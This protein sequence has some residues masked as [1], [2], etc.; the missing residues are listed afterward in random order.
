MKMAHLEALEERKVKKS[1]EDH[2]IE[3]V[4]KLEAAEDGGFQDK[5][6]LMQ[7]Y[8]HFN[9]AVKLQKQEIKYLNTMAYFLILVGNHKNALT[10]LATS[11]KIDPKND[12]ALK[13]QQSVQ[14]IMHMTP[15]QKQKYAVEAFSNRPYPKSDDDFDALY[16]A[17]EDFIEEQ[18][19][20]FMQ[21]TVSPEVTLDAAKVDEQQKM[22]AQL[23]EIQETVVEKLKIL[24]Q[25]QDVSALWDKTRNLEALNTRYYNSLRLNSIF[26]MVLDGINEARTMTMEIFQEIKQK[27]D[28]EVQALDLDPQINQ[29]YDYCDE[30]ADQLDRLSQ[31]TNIYLLEREYESLIQFVQH[32]QDTLDDY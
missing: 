12:S 29:I 19:R 26:M 20:Y 3:G 22:F 9:A 6:A 23:E 27:S 10:Y 8:Q 25:D 4:K 32:L 1:A 24:E 17:L 16:E 18:T 7:I 28:D 13:L 14:D 5:N 30:L 21:S 2:Y 31:E 15:L 11:L